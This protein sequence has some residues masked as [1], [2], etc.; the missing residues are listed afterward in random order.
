MKNFSLPAAQIRGIED[1]LTHAVISLGSMR[2]ALP[3]GETRD[4][5]QQRYDDLSTFA[6]QL[7]D[8]IKTNT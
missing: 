7:R 8:H 4:A 1:A 3:F 2:W 6:Q 5:M